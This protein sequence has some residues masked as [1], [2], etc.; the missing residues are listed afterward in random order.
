MRNSEL[1][2]ALMSRTLYEVIDILETLH[3]ENRR[4]VAAADT[5]L[6]HLRSIDQ[7]KRF[8]ITIK[9]L[10]AIRETADHCCRVIEGP[11]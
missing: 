9:L 3:A 7:A 1:D 6:L 8:D 10:Q 11:Q 2:A 4:I 5:L